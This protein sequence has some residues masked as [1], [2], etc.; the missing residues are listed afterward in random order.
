MADYGAKGSTQGFNVK[1]VADQLLSFS[2]SFPTPGIVA[3][4]SFSSNGTLTHNLGYYP[5]IMSWFT[6][7]E[8]SPH[9]TTMTDAFNSGIGVNTISVAVD[10]GMTRRM[11]VTNI[12]LEQNFT[13]STTGSNETA[14]TDQDFYIKVSK[15][16]KDV[17]STDLRDLVVD[18]TTRAPM[19]HRVASGTMTT[20][21]DMST[22][23]K[24]SIRTGLGY[25]AFA[26]CF[27]K[28]ATESVYR[29]CPYPV[30]ATFVPFYDIQGDEVSVYA[31][32][33]DYPTAP[34]Y[35]IVILKNRQW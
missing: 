27:A 35:S 34:K 23:W 28:A 15:D 12:D 24:A 2:S 16:G 13:A 17:N 25:N 8:V 30:G 1:D 7:T 6:T 10:P 22:R 11:Y 18:T 26:Y 9:R 20:D 14:G 19:I 33:D 4:Q 31:W 5:F 29:P 32:K 3:T 21:P